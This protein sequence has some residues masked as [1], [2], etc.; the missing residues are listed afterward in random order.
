MGVSI[1]VDDPFRSP[2]SIIT[3]VRTSILV[4]AAAGDVALA[5]IDDGD[6]ILSVTHFAFTLA[7]GLPNTVTTAAA[8]LTSEFT[9]KDG[10]GSINNTG[11]TS[12][13]LGWL[14]V[15]WEDHDYGDVTEVPWNTVTD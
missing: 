1:P 8:D 12:S 3:R 9:I 14:I 10:G 6:R 5:A 11:G 4:G 15:T 13:A 7:E 2:T